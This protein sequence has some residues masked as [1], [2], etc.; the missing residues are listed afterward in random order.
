MLQRLQLDEGDPGTRGSDLQQIGGE[1]MNAIWIVLWISSHPMVN[2][3]GK[4]YATMWE[5]RY[6]IRESSEGAYGWMEILKKQ[7]AGFGFRVF[8][9]QAVY[10]DAGFYTQP[11]KEEDS[12][13]IDFSPLKWKKKK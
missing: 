12:I 13:F 1:L 11:G 6:S 3:Q 4:Q 7:G 5:D 8:E 10:G 2:E 9:G